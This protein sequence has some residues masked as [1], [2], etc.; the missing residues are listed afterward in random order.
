MKNAILNEILKLKFVHR[1][2]LEPGVFT[3]DY[4][5]PHLENVI[6][7]LEPIDFQS[8]ACLDIGTRDGGIAFL[9]EKRGASSVIAL[10]IENRKQFSLVHKYLQS[11]VQY[12]TDCHV[13]EMED[14]LSKIQPKKFDIIILSSVL[15]HIYDVF[16]TLAQTRNLLKPGGLLIV[17]T[18]CIE[19]PESSLY[20]NFEG[21]FYNDSYAY[22]FPT[23]SCFKQLLSLCSFQ[24]LS[25]L[26]EKVDPKH[27]DLLRYALTA[28]AVKPSIAFNGN[29]WMKKRL[30]MQYGQDYARFIER[31]LD[32]HSL[33]LEELFEPI[34]YNIT[35]G[36]PNYHIGV[37]GIRDYI[38]Q[39][40][41]I[42]K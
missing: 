5:Q 31:P 1:I 16:G 8:L 30:D 25:D 36:S 23:I 24:L 41:K 6:Q 14:K 32:Y 2:E 18:A 21:Y 28:R 35:I 33:E 19:S 20:F 40:L 29:D 4:N 26:R 34:P 7:L 38:K 11:N 42:K 27:G 13:N 12:I 22:W 3:C 39:R 37:M 17:E 9:L 15:N 10:D